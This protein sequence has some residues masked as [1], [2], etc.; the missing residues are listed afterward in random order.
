MN[1]IVWEAMRF[2][3]DQYEKAGIGQAGDYSFPPAEMLTLL[4]NMNM[5]VTQPEV[6][7]AGILFNTI[8]DTAATL[9]MIRE[10][11]GDETTGLVAGLLKY[12]FF[13]QEEGPGKQKEDLA[14]ATIEMRVLVLCETVVKQRHLK[15]ELAVMGDDVWKKRG[16]P[17]VIMCTYLSRIQDSLYDLQFDS[18]TAPVYWEMVDTFKDLFVTFYYDRERQR[19]I[20][21]CESGENYVIAKSDLREGH[22]IWEIPKGA[23]VVNRRYA[24]RIEDNWREEYDHEKKA[25]GI[26]FEDYFV[27]VKEHL[28]GFLTETS[29]SDLNMLAIVNLEYIRARYEADLT[30]LVNGETSVDLFLTECPA[31]TADELEKVMETPK[32]ADRK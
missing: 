15:E 11:F 32:P 2:A 22:W 23:V 19:L 25:S 10:Q 13:I 31:M 17:K 16:I 26:R 9:N 7:A 12:L 20:Q 29:E 3:I 4:N 30:R 5:G 27:A 28:R 21:I 8:E 6:L 14:N 18:M 1:N 24:E